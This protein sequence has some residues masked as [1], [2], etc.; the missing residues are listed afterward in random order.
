MAAL[1]A[2]QALETV[3]LQAGQTILIHGAAG[4]VGT[5]AVQFAREQGARFEYRLV[6]L[7]APKIVKVRYSRTIVTGETQ[8]VLQ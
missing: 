2:W 6:R 8:G 1:T 7:T 4:G 3:G 5:F